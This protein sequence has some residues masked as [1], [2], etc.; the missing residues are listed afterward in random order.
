M[1]LSLR[2]LVHY[3]NSD[4]RHMQPWVPLINYHR[5]VDQFIRLGLIRPRENPRFVRM[6]LLD[7]MVT[8]RGTGEGEA[9][10]IVAGV[11]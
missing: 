4:W 1:G 11:V 7:S 2:R 3:I 6:V 8:E 9:N 10:T 5:Y